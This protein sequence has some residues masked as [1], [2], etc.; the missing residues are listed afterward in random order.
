MNASCQA[1]RHAPGHALDRVEAAASRALAV[2][3]VGE[4]GNSG[5]DTGPMKG[6]SSD[7]LFYLGMNFQFTGSY[8]DCRAAAP[9]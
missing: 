7:T 6:N 4:N 1:M 2:S 8:T 3:S 5:A 9:F